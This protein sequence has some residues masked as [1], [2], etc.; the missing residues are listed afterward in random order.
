MTA[1]EQII[2][3]DDAGP[4]AVGPI[5]RSGEIAE[6]VIDAIAEDNPG[7]QVFVVDRGD[8]IRVHVDHHCVLRKSTMEKHLGREYDLCRLEIEMP[9]FAGRIRTTVDA[10][11]WYH[12][13]IAA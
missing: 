11:T 1:E 6:A 9:S 2:Q 10:Y 12:G 13:A 5:I 4:E 7:R 3:A 8:Y